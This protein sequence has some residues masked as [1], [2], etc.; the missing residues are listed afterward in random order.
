MHVP[1]LGRFIAIG[2]LPVGLDLGNV[3]KLGEGLVYVGR[4]DYPG[5]HAIKTLWFTPPSFFGS[6]TVRVKR[7]DGPG[8]AGIGQQPPGGTFTAPAGPTANML[9]GWRNFPSSTWVSAPGCYAWMISGHGLHESIVLR[10]KR[11]AQSAKR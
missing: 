3:G 9:R 7:L 4:Q 10:V 2:K 1:L 6:F 11:M 5:W 8:R